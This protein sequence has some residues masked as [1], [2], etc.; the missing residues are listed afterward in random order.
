MSG[1]GTVL[2]ATDLSEPATS[3]LRH[4]A[5]LAEL[6]GGR[7][8]VTF[9]VEDRLPPLIAAQTPDVDGLLERHRATA[10]TALHD[11]VA[12]HLAGRQVELVIRLGTVHDEIVKL[13]RERQA[14]VI[15]VGM[16]GHGFLAHALAGSTA[17]RVLHHAPCPV[18]VVP[19]DS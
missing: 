11:Y 15:V 5:A 18:L 7:L 16:H 4:G 3:A 2:V 19:H 13:A 14:D 1:Y 12:K 8:T 10:D 6:S 9:V 17:E